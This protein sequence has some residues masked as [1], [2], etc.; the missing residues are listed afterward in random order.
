MRETVSRAPGALAS[1][2]PGDHLAAGA[3]GPGA[4]RRAVLFAVWALA[5]L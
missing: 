1:L 2:R 3:A 5:G 4:D